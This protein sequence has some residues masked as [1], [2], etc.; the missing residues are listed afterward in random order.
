MPPS[1]GLRFV[2]VQTPPRW[3]T[4]SAIHAPLT[5]MPSG[6][7]GPLRSR[8]RGFIAQLAGRQLGERLM[9]GKSRQPPRWRIYIDNQR[10][11]SAA[12][13]KPQNNYRISETTVTVAPG[14]TRMADT[15]AAMVAPTAWTRL[16]SCHW[17]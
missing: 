9:D 14:T 8:T 11:A 1:G 3:L 16:K 6:H 13:V 7:L 12:S 2:Y 15:H 10:A 4:R 17:T 5:Q